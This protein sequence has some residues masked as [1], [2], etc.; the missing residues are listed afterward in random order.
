VPKRPRSTNTWR[1]PALSVGQ[2][3]PGNCGGWRLIDARVDF[4]VS[5]RRFGAAGT[6]SGEDAMATMPLGTLGARGQ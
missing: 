4:P 5:V 1:S 6:C 2:F 3:R